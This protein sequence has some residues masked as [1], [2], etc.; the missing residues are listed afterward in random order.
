MQ[1]S[2]VVVEK[3]LGVA[4]SLCKNLDGTGLPEGEGQVNAFDLRAQNREG[5]K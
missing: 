3:A 2:V 4:L 5:E 1:R